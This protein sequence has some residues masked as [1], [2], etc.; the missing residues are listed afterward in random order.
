M[1]KLF[2]QLIPM[3]RNDK[4]KDS[5]FLKVTSHLAVHNSVLADKI[6]TGLSEEGSN[7]GH[8]LLSVSSNMETQVSGLLRCVKTLCSIYTSVYQ[9]MSSSSSSSLSS[10]SSII[11]GI[12]P[13]S[14]KAVQIFKPLEVL[15]QLLDDWLNLLQAEFDKNEKGKCQ[16]KSEPVTEK[17]KNDSPKENVQSKPEIITNENGT[18]TSKVSE[19]PCETV[20]LSKEHLFK[21]AGGDS[22]QCKEHLLI[23]WGGD[24]DVIGTVL[25]RICGVIHAFYI[26]CSCQ[27]SHPQMT[28]PRFIEFVC[29][30][31]KVLKSLVARNPKVI[32]D[33]FHFLLECPE[34]MSQFLHIIKA[35]S[36][37]DRREWFYENL[38]T[39]RE[40]TLVHS[41]PQ[42]EDI[43]V[44]KRD[45]MFKS[46]CNEMLKKSSDKLKKGLAIKF[47]GEEGVGHGVVREWFDILSNEILNPDYALFTQSAD[48]STFQPNSN[49]AINPDHL[50]FFQFAGQTLGLALYHQYLLNVHLESIDERLA[51]LDS[52]AQGSKHIRRKNNL[53]ETFTNF[54]TMLPEKKTLDNA[55]PEDVK[56]FLVW[57]DGSG[58][59]KIHDLDCKFLGQNVDKNCNCPVRMASASVVNIVQE[60][61][62][63]FHKQG[64]GRVFNDFKCQGNPAASS[65]VKLYLK[66]IKEEQA[67][68]HVL[69]KQAKPIFISKLEAISNYIDNRLQCGG[70]NLTEVF[71][72]SRDQA[73]FK[74]QFFAGDRASDIG[75]TMGQEIKILEDGSGLLVNHTYGE[76]LRGDGKCNTFVLKKCK[77]L[78]IC[79][80]EGINRYLRI[81]KSMGVSLAYGY[82]FRPMSD[83]GTVLNEALSYSAIYERLRE[84][85]S[86]VGLYDGETPHSFR[87]GC[88]VHMLMSKSAESVDDMRQ[89]IGWATDESAKYYSREV[90]IK[91]ATKTADKLASSLCSDEVESS[92]PVNYTDVA[93]I[94]PE[95]AKNLQWILDHNIDSLGLDLTF[96]VE[97]DVFG[98][99]QEVQLKPG[100]AKVPVNE[101]NKEEYVQLV[102]E[103]RM[104]RAIQPQIDSFLTG[105]HEYIPQ[106]LVQ[107]FD[108]YELELMLSGIPEIDV[109]DWRNFTEYIGYDADMDVIKWF[110]ETLEGFS[111]HDRVLLLQFATGSSRV[112]FG[113]FAK[114]SSGGG[115]MKFTISHV[116][117]TGSI[118]P[119]ASTW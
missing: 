65:A 74:M 28:S 91:D 117:Y 108:E 5:V 109:D 119:T 19:A 83:L 89:H 57:K 7:I 105:F 103:L 85:L 76:T 79:P 69:P 95:Y 107:M 50:N 32:F 100:G 78:S 77:N 93:S 29:A 43:V 70:V 72:L 39:E 54:L 114:L 52:V 56:R 2:D 106:S 113:G 21:Q 110:W 61:V 112:P 36:F 68:F 15:W 16:V 51:Y 64:R 45:H 90:L 102:T 10:Q 48:G 13:I 60:L 63:I 86:R 111:Q 3:I 26:C 1:P 8:N 59:T 92:I 62:D 9:S 38:T 34:L 82:L 30:H 18:K 49:S 116:T 94:D 11:N 4:I 88:A 80:V 75:M 12:T 37:D 20:H 104:T 58:K 41:P 14:P 27:H 98:V 23:Q 97:T 71:V 66:C 99:M 47:D 33:H 22:P 31:N 118:L 46:S 101:E 55:S 44:V 42:E 96:S 40:R 81:S 67:K 73:L 53:R 6:L 35:Q 25:P 17:K 84:Y 87:A 24:Q 115:P